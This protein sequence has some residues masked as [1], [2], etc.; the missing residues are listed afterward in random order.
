[1]GRASRRATYKLFT[2]RPPSRSLHSW[3]STLSTL[4]QTI[5]LGLWRRPLPNRPAFNW[6]RGLRFSP[7]Q[8]LRHQS[9]GPSSGSGA[10]PPPRPPHAGSAEPALSLSQRMRKLSREYGW[11]ALGVYFML[12]ALDF[13]LCFLA[14][15]MLGA[16]RIGRWEHTAISWVRSVIPGPGSS[17]SETATEP[18]EPSEVPADPAAAT[19]TEG[20]WSIRRAREAASGSNASIWTQLALAYAIHKSFM[21]VR[22]PMTAFITPYVVRVLRGWGWNI[23]KRPLKG[24]ASTK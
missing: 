1:M 23:G 19:A 16:D 6:H 20:R 5:R 18:R 2:T 14:V 15:Q 17:P 4:Q 11:S 10:R 8:T 24:A 7:R 21:V 9:S 22:I 12:S 3:F 13:P